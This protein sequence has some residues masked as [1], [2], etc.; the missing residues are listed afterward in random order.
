MNVIVRTPLKADQIQA[1]LDGYQSDGVS[2]RFLSR[3]GISLTFQCEGI[4]SAGAIALVKALIRN[5]DYG[6]VL[7]FSVITA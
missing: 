3:S 7:N 2:L 6:K 1:L 4:D 5:T